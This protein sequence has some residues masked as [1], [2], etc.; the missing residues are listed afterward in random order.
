MRILQHSLLQIAHFWALAV[1]RVSSK[2]GTIMHRIFRIQRPT[3]YIFM[4]YVVIL[5]RNLSFHPFI[6]LSLFN[7]SLSLRNTRRTP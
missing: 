2:I 3:K 5:L 4:L 7:T 6:S 1:A